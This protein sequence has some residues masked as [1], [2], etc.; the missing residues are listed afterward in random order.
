M[1]SFIAT[2]A[3]SPNDALIPC[4]QS[5]VSSWRGFFIK[6]ENR[7]AVQSVPMGL[8]TYFINPI[9]KMVENRYF[10]PMDQAIMGFR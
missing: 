2:S 7:A 1:T 10:R 4:V 6:T 3:K 8:I 9:V 5:P